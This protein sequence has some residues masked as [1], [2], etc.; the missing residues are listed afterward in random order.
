MAELFEKDKAPKPSG[1]SDDDLKGNPPLEPSGLE[2]ELFPKGEV[3]HEKVEI[4]RYSDHGCAQGR[5]V[6]A[7]LEIPDLCRDMGI[8]TATFYNWRAKYSG[9]D[10]SMMSCMKDR[11]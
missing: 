8:S 7:G 1:I 9:M 10:V 4:Y 2:V 11:G 3:L 5:R 6:E